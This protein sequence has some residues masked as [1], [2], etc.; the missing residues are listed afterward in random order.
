MAVLEAWSY[1]LPVVMTDACH[2]PEGF[3][4]NAAIRIQPTCE[5]IARELSQLLEMSD[6]ERETMGSR[7]R[8]LVEQLFSWDVIGANMCKIYNQA[9][10]KESLMAR[11]IDC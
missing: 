2:L 9:C 5:S 11:K 4:A 7:G 6:A 8:S 3:A 1:G 10:G